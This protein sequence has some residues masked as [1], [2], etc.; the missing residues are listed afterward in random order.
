MYVCVSCTQRMYARMYALIVE[1]IEEAVARAKVMHVY[2]QKCIVGAKVIH[3]LY[4]PR[5]HVY[6][7]AKVMHGVG[8]NEVHD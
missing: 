7:C 2:V 3:V 6:V 1:A 8:A 4:V 5:S